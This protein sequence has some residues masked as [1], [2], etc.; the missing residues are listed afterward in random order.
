[1]FPEAFTLER[2]F[3]WYLEHAL[4]GLGQKYLD[5]SVKI[6][7][8]RSRYLEHGVC[9]LRAFTLGIFRQGHLHWVFLVKDIRAGAF[10]LGHLGQRDF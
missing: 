6:G 8:F 7:G 9:V 4:A 10:R 5:R 2:L 1:M 3:C